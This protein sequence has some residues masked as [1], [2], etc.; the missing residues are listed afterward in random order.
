MH[1]PL[2]RAVGA[3]TAVYGALVTARPDLLAKPSGLTTPD[4]DV[5]RDTEICLRPL[6]WR[7]LAVG[8]AMATAPE[9]PALRT[10]TAVRIASDLGDALLLGPTLDREYRPK[11]LA[12]SVGWAALSV[13]GLYARRGRTT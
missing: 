7:D 4:G 12:V 8:I 3:A 10:A 9:G 1:T 11:V 13:I 6:V 5:P 2:L